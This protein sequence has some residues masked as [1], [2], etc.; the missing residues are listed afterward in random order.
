MAI[1]SQTRGEQLVISFTGTSPTMANAIRR[2]IL[3]EVPTFAIEDVEIIKNDSSLYDET[4]AHRLGLIPLVTD[5]ESYNLRSACKCG[6]IGCALCEVKFSLKS[7]EEG[8]V[9][10][11]TLSSN[12]PNVIPADGKIPVTKL[13]TNQAIEINMTAVLGKGAEH[14]KWAPAHAFLQEKEDA[15]DLIVE[16]FGQLTGNQ[17][18]NTAIDE[19]TKKCDELEAKL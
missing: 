7:D 11:S 3:D 9:Y 8:Y 13:N 19:L 16:P 1:S 12:D 18:F 14:A 15:V 17:I 2:V 5:L 10:V 6:G 4:V